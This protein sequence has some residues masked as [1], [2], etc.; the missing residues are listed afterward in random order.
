MASIV[1]PY[2]YICMYIYD[3]SDAMRQETCRG[4]AN[5]RENEPFIIHEDCRARLVIL[6]VYPRVIDEARGGNLQKQTWFFVMRMNS[7]GAME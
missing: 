6:C 4:S 1:R 7:A 3:C 5:T 2:T